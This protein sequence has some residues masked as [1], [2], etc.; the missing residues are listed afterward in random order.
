M[1]HGSPPAHQIHFSA[2]VVPLG[3]KKKVDRAKVNEVL[4][5]SNNKTPLSATVEVQRYGI[6]YTIPTSELQFMP[7]GG[8]VYRNAL[9]L[10]VAS[11]DSAG[12]FLSWRADVGTSNLNSATYKELSGSN[13][14]VHQ[15]VQIPTEAISVRLGIQDRMSDQLGTVEIGLPILPPLDAPKTKR[16]LPEIEPD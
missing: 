13:F 2:R 1:Q 4:L 15:E 5:A 14:Q 3:N 8:G 9:V 6:N 7:A 12:N 10:M 16:S 11:F